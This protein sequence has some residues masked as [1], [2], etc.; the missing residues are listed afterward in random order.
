LPEGANFGSLIHNDYRI[1]PD[2]EQE[3]RAAVE[4]AHKAGKEIQYRRRADGPDWKPCSFP[5]W[6]WTH[7]DYRVAPV[8][9]LAEIKSAFKAGKPVQA[10]HPGGQ[11]HDISN[12]VFNGFDACTRQGSIFRLKPEPTLRP[13]T[14]D[15]VP[16]GAVLR[17]KDDNRSRGLILGVNLRGV[18]TTTTV[19][20]ELSRRSFQS[21][22][23]CAEH[24]L[25][26]GKTWGPCGVEVTA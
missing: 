14:A 10:K 7:C 2:A 22:L 5:L 19:V 16:V 3:R 8:D 15:E 6:N 4:A 26:G 1:K 18:A 23:D 25:D 9:P 17:R 12:R 20:N 24:S 11:W 21:L 13:W